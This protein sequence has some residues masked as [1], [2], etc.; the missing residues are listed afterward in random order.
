MTDLFREEPNGMFSC[1]L[2]EI[3]SPEEIDHLQRI[4][5]SG[6]TAEKTIQDLV[7]NCVTDHLDLLHFNGPDRAFN[8]ETWKWE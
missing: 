2:R 6:I 1:D 7:I 5:D 8:V 3:F 4:V